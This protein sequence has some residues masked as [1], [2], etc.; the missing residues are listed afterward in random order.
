MS[1]STA[2]PSRRTPA[3]ARPDLAAP[4]P[5]EDFTRP[6]YETEDGGNGVCALTV[7]H[8]VT[9]A[10]ATDAQISGETPEAAGWSLILSNLKT[11]VETGEPLCALAP[12]PIPRSGALRGT[13]PLSPEAVPRST[14]AEP[15]PRVRVRGFAMAHLAGRRRDVYDRHQRELWELHIAGRLR[16]A[17]HAVL[18]LEEAAE[19]HLILE[20]RANRGKVV[21][22][23]RKSPAGK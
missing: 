22:S 15:P 7:T 13:D 8:G 6:T 18:P 23:P 2:R 20:A 16:P 11:L 1:S 5:R 17:I 4:V 21:L 9:G 3:A 10:P 14:P 19:A 12:L